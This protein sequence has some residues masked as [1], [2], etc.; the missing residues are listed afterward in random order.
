MRTFKI[1]VKQR[2]LAT[3]RLVFGVG[4]LGYLIWQAEPTRIVQQWRALD[5]GWLLL[6]IG[7]MIGGVFI[8]GYKWWLLLRAR[9]QAVSYGWAVRAYFI[10]SFFNNFLPT[11]I[12]GD[13]VRA[14]LLSARTGQASAAIASI[15]VE[16]MTGFI[17]L[18]VIACVSL[19]LNYATLAD[20]PQLLLGAGLLGLVAVALTTLA[21]VAAPLARLLT[22]LRLPDVAGWRR[23]LHAMAESLS[24]YRQHL[25]TLGI[26][27]AISFGYQLV[28]IGANYAAA[29]SLGLLQP[30]ALFT[31]MVPMSDIVGL[32]PIFPNN[33]GARE[34]TFVVL[35]GQV[36]EESARAL[37]LAFLIFGVRL[38]VS[39]IGGVLYLLGSERVGQKE[40]AA[41]ERV[42]SSISGTTR[43]DE[44]TRY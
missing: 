2:A 5:S 37:A 44:A 7:L 11:M 1:T 8:S 39:L 24:S 22:R 34:G 27:I 30:F 42:E 20:A 13:A 38:I 33:L 29:R 14:Y 17:A 4:L 12:G 21:L 26:A 10:G 16:R 3:L 41:P 31:L 23:K 43:V 25:G 32:A 40:Q 18:T 19:W 28:W 6:S 15:F 35:L 36:G 9:A